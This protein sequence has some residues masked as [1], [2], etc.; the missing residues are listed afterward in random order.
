MIKKGA[1]DS[2]LTE[3]GRPLTTCALLPMLP[4]NLEIEA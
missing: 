1:T 3:V 2:I 4:F